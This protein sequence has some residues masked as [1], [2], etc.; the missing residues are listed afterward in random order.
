MKH[1][2]MLYIPL[3]SHL[4]N[5]EMERD[6]N[7]VR[8]MQL[9]HSGAKMCRKCFTAYDRCTKQLSSLRASLGKLA[10]K[11]H[12]E[13]DNSENGAAMLIPPPKGVA[14]CFGPSTASPD[15]TVNE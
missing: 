13:S 5:L 12:N 7:D 1:L 9:V 3:L 2:I 8:A 15:V 14:V 11:I 10:Q 4:V 6:R